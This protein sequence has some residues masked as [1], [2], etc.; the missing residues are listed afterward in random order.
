MTTMKLAEIKGTPGR[1][2]AYRKLP[3]LHFSGS[4][5]HFTTLDLIKISQ[6]LRSPRN[7]LRPPPKNAG[8][9]A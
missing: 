2:E 7:L 4:S 5:L 9:P 6:I 3:V 8:R 1:L